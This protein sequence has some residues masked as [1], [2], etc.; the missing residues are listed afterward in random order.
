M[1]DMTRRVVLELLAKNRAKGE[2]AAFNRGIGTT[3]RSVRRLAG[4]LMVMAGVGG[5]GYMIK[6]QMAA[7]DSTA[8]LSD[9]LGMTTEALIGMQHG[10]SIAGVEQGTLNKSL[11]IFSRRLGEVDMGV[12]QAKYAL[13]KLGLSYE[14]LIGKSPDEAIGIVADQI[15]KLG[16]QAEKAAAANYLFGRSGQQL[17]NLFEKG[18]KGLKEYEEY[19]RKTGVA[20]SRIDAA[21]IEAANDALT[22]MKVIFT[23]LF[24]TTAIQLAPYIEAAA[25]AF[26]NFAISGEGV[27]VNVTN[28]FESIALAAAKVAEEI[29]WLIIKMSKLTSPIDNLKK[30]SEANKKAIDQYRTVTGDTNAFTTP[31]GMLSM[32]VQPRD[33]M[34]FDVISRVQKREAGLMPVDRESKIIAGFDD[35]RQRAEANAKARAIE[36]EAARKSG[37]DELEIVTETNDAIIADHQRVIAV[38]V[39]GMQVYHDE[40]QADMAQSALYTS[41]KFAE[42]A[43][44]IEGSM[45][46]A[47]ES[48]ISGG[49][50]WKDAM[51]NFFTE[52]GNA[53]AKMVA[54]MVARALM[55]Q[56]VS[57]LMGM[58]GGMA[59]GAGGSMTTAGG[60]AAG[61]GNPYFLHSG[62]IAGRDG[63]RKPVPFGTFAN[64]PRMH[65][66]GLAGD[67]VPAILQKGERVIPKGEDTGG[68]VINN[69]YI[70]AIDTQSFQQALGKEKHFL[71]DLHFQGLKSN[72]PSRRYER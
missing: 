49:S 25:T 56:A 41:D 69:T 29:E 32:P 13:D 14:E 33:P 72:H 5:I 27:G 4:G 64:A 9:R 53:F 55:A 17:L 35:I 12:G 6:Q 34:M 40:L 1:A 23:G 10:A 36:V 52:I 57:S 71:D 60:S 50:D 38:R 20:F 39:G 63:I 70:N 66:G 44:S 45:S 68:T 18:S 58:F 46:G 28:A 67:E 51:S 2:M 43:R 21:Q 11:E 37:A 19:L 3:F 42:A 7:I 48:M 8:K 47:F 15:N 59:A 16:T 62:G 65:I 31:G 26:N 54:D 30:I 61:G 22:N 24:T